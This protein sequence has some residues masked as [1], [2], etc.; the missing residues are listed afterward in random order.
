MSENIFAWIADRIIT[1]FMQKYLHHALTHRRGSA[2][3]YDGKALLDVLGRMD[4]V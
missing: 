2:N 1:Y 4:T 3:T